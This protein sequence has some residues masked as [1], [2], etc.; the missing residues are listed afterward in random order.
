[1]RITVGQQQ[2]QLI[3]KDNVDIVNEKCITYD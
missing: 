2:K 1:M 3:F